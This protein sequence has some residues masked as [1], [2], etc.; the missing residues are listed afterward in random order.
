MVLNFDRGLLLS[1]NY[2]DFINKMLYI[3]IMYTTEWMK[4]RDIHIYSYGVLYLDR[5]LDLACKVS[6]YVPHIVG[7]TEGT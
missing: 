1:V 6:R 5:E 3:L 2:L 4:L 7:Y